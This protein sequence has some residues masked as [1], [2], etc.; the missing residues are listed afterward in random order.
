MEKIA[1]KDKTYFT[2]QDFSIS[3][4]VSKKKKRKEIDPHRSLS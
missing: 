1:K 3:F 4:A 2:A